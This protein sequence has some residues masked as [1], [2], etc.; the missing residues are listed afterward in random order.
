MTDKSLF[1]KIETWIDAHFEETVADI[2]NLV[3]IPSV[4]VYDEKDTPYGR[5][6]L[7]AIRFM[8][9]RARSFGFETRRV[10]DRVLE[11][12]EDLSFSG[13]SIWCHLDVVPAGDGWTYTKPFEPLRLGDYLIGRGADDNKGPAAACLYLMRMLKELGIKTQNPIRLCL[14]TDEEK[15]MSDVKLYAATQPAAKLNLVADCGFPVCY[16]EKGILE[17]DVVS[18]EPCESLTA[19]RAGSASNII[20]DRAEMLLRTK[21]GSG[22][23]Q[24]GLGENGKISFE[25]GLLRI[26]ATGLAAHSAHPERGLN[27]ISVLTQA[28]LESGALDGYTRRVLTFFDRINAGYSGAALG[29][30]Y[31]DETSGETTCAGTVAS[32]DADGRARLRLNIRYAVSADAEKMLISME[33]SCRENGCKLTN[34]SDSRPNFFP[35]DSPIIKELTDTFNLFSG[36]DKQPY[37]MSGGTYARKL[38]NAVGYGL[39]GLDK[40]ETNLFPPG[41][42]GAHQ[43]DEALYLP[44]L[45]KAMAL[46]AMGLMEADEVLSRS[47]D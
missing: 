2:E 3:R 9:D 29:I 46:F 5:E 35:P 27:A 43:C 22:L 45:K 33:A 25:D 19:F 26:L 18:I 24:K 32:L 21:N 16:A 13:I 30:S 1:E 28:A 11:I 36:Q 15:R 34:V 10:D 8:E 31:S 4:A 41:H 12:S 42:G 38:P 37:C 23:A 7:R 47:P 39:G 14:G 44:N 6:C 40:P 17:A 20:P